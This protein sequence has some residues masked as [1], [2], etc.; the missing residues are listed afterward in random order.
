MELSK[1]N[2]KVV[3]LDKNT[4]IV[5]KNIK[6]LDDDDIDTFEKLYKALRASTDNKSLKQAKI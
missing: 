6:P 2:F 1:V 4:D 5:F 3:S